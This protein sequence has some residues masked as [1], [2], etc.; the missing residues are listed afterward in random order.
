MK[1]SVDGTRCMGHGRCYATAPDLLSYDDDGYV[2]I[3]G[4]MMDV[5]EAQ[6]TAA[7]EAAAN[8]PER[9]IELFDD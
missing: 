9:A 5:P 2:T 6:A 7:R 1:L 3:R 4:Q 8:C